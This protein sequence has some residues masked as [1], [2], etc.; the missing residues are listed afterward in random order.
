MTKENHPSGTDRIGEIALNI[1]AENII[2]IQEM[3][4]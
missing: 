3:S 4:L 1:E 2:N